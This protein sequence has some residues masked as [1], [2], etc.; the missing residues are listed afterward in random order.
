MMAPE[1]VQ[2]ESW[3]G[4]GV[5][6]VAIETRPRSVRYSGFVIETIPRPLAIRFDLVTG[7]DH[8]VRSLT[9]ERLGVD[10]RIALEHDGQGIWYT[11][12]ERMPQL[13]GVL[14]PDISVTP[15][16]NTF[17]IRRLA[18]AEGASANI[19]TAYVDVAAMTVLADAQRYT[20]LTPGRLYRY[21]SRDSDF[22]ADIALGDD[23]LVDIYPG[24]FRRRI[25]D[26]QIDRL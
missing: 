22:R 9:V 10:G 12:G 20:C 5:Q 3:D 4:N 18:L 24:L 23:G 15:L 14:E 11:G 13:D 19:L 16:T 2:W 21:E 6:H 7:E 1:H 17:P 8:I 25:A 26:R